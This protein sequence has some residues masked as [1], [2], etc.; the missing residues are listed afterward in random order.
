MM[1]YLF[2]REFFNYLKTKYPYAINWEH[3]LDA[4]DNNDMPETVRR[5]WEEYKAA[6]ER[7][8]DAKL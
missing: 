2:S 4:S 7:A 5:E 8:G 3:I 6:R 1:Y